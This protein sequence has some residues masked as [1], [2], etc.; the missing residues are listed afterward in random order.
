MNIQD[1]DPKTQQW[2]TQFNAAMADAGQRRAFIDSPLESLKQLGGSIDATQHDAVARGIQAASLAFEFRSRQEQ[3]A[4]RG[5]LSKQQSSDF[6]KYFHL[7][8]EWWGF[9]MRIDHAAIKELP[10]GLAAVGT[11]AEAAVGV[12]KA[13]AEAGP[14]AVVVALGLAYWGAI[15]TAYMVLLPELDKGKGVYLTVTW[16][17]IG[18]AVA[19]GGLIGFAA[20]PVPTT[21]V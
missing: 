1:F 19:S 9:V 20:L 6:E 16:P 5:Q 4:A 2:L 10:K 13:A 8:V 7:K 14:L 15:F 3:A 21:V 18:I 17:Q 11:L 12:V